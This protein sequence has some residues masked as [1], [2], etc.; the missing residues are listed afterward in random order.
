MWVLTQPCFSL[1]SWFS[2]CVFQDRGQELVDG[3]KVCLQGGSVR[4]PVLCL[5]SLTSGPWS[6][7]WMGPGVWELRTVVLSTSSLNPGLFQLL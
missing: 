5:W 7:A 2:R 6:C 4:S 1:N 3:L